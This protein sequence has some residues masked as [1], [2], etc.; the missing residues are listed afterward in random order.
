MPWNNQSGG[1]GRGGG[2]GPWGNQPG[3]GGQR[4]NGR[5]PQQPPDL[6]ELFRKGA[7]RFKG[8]FPG[9]GLGSLLIILVL[10]AGWLFTGIYKVETD[11]LG[12]VLRFGKYTNTTLPGLHYHMPWPIES[13]LTPP[14]QT[15]KTIS[16]GSS[17]SESQMLTGDENIVDLQFNVQWRI[18]DAPKFLF[19]VAY[20]EIVIKSTA[21]SVMRE[22]VG[23]NT[24]TFVTQDGRDQVQADVRK[25]T[26]DVLDG[27]NA[28]IYI[29]QVKLVRVDPH[30]SVVEAYRDVQAARADRERMRN[31][32][33][34]YANKVVPE[35]EGKAARTVAEAEAF[36]E[37]AVRG[38]EG[39]AQRFLSV[40]GEYKNAPGVTR[41]RIFIETME[42]VLAGRNKVILDEGAGGV[43]PYLP[44]GELSKK[45]SN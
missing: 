28:G 2:G 13:A 20:P 18:A 37:Q 39:E 41:Q 25:G 32:A 22:V 42:E 43:V 29:D 21:E 3:G 4:P 10:F 40:Y 7:E 9:G 36:K 6:D 27:Y 5:G 35:A 45:S 19:N 14:V 17:E 11:E 33:E 15:Q 24:L 31:E 38:A 16:I 8:G 1:G 44:L 12:V 23:Q 30:K 26:Q 34:A